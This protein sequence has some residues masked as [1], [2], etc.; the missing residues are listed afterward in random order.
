MAQTT[1][2][3]TEP[4]PPATA[5]AIRD[6]FGADPSRMTM[7]AARKFAV[8]EQ[9]VLDALVGQWPIVRLREGG[10]RELMEGLPGLGTMRV[11]VRS[12]AAVIESVGGFGGYSESGPF[13][14]VQTDTLDMHIL[15]AEIK[16]IYAVEKTG[17]DSDFRTYS[18]QLFDHSGDAAFKAFLWQDFPKVPAEHIA[19]F[20]ELA[21]RLSE[22]P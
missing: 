14:N 20:N 10:F 17:H 7:M 11:F 5:E 6:W 1:T 16:T 19:A 22:T 9:T 3:P 4:I 12:K 13:F 2:T 21:R 15:Y 8:P 18:F